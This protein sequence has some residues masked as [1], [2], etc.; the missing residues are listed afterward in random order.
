MMHFKN[1]HVFLK[2][3]SY[4]WFVVSVLFFTGNYSE[5]ALGLPAGS[6]IQTFKPLVCTTLTT[7]MDWACHHTAVAV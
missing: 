2:L 1:L 5:V 3:L 4:L 7:E 6:T